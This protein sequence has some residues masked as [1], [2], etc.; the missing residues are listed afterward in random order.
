MS[1]RTAICPSCERKTPIYDVDVIEG[2][3]KRYGLHSDQRGHY[4][5]MSDRLVVA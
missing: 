2:P 5:P 3:R 1:T 4:C